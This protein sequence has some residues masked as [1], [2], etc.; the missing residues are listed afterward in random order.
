MNGLNKKTTKF[1]RFAC[2]WW[3]DAFLVPVKQI[4][5]YY[6]TTWILISKS[7]FTLYLFSL[8]VGDVVVINISHRVFSSFLTKSAFFP[9][10][11]GPPTETLS[12]YLLS[13]RF[14]RLVKQGKLVKLFP[15]DIY[16]YPSFIEILLIQRTV[17][18]LFKHSLL[19]L[20]FEQKFSF[21]N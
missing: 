13:D 14:L 5:R 10:Q 19:L 7:D 6:C 8:G 16:R 4:K 18:L 9:E 15:L 21:S 11:K 1:S 2:R 12:K 17:D 20:F 3:L